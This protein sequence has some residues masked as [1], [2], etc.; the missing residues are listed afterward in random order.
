MVKCVIPISIQGGFFMKKLFVTV[1]LISIFSLFVFGAD[2]AVVA[3]NG[4]AATLY[5]ADMTDNYS[6]QV[7]RHIYEGLVEF[8]GEMNV[9]PALA[10]SWDIAADGMTYT[11]YLQED[12]KFQDGM[13]FHA[14]AVKLHF[15]KLLAGDLRR[16]SL[17]VP[18]VE[19]VKVVDD[20]TVKFNM[21][22][23]FG[24]FLN[25]L[26]HGAGLIVSPGILENFPKEEISN[27]PVGT[28][29]YEFVEWSKGDHIQLK[30]YD[31]YWQG[32]PKLDGINF[33][34]VPEANTRVLMLESGDSD[35]SD[36]IEPINVPRLEGKKGVDIVVTPSLT[37]RYVGFNMTKPPFDNKLVRQAAN[38]AIDKKGMAE[39]L[40][41]GYANPAKSVIAP[42][43]N[44]YY[45]T[46]GYPYNP[47]KAKELLAEAG[48]P[49]GFKTTLF[50]APH[51]K[52]IAVIVQSQLKAVGIDAKIDVLEWAS[53]MDLLY[54][55]SP[56]ESEHTMYVIGWS[57]STGDADWVV[58]PLF[59]SDN[60]PPNGDNHVGMA[61]DRVDELLK[62]E[63]TTFDPDERQEYLTELQKLLV[64]Q[65][66]WIF[67]YVQDE[68]VG[69]NTDLKDV[70]VLPL[71]VTVL[72]YAYFE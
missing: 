69:V 45:E 7:C 56:A 13:P 66:P 53:Y 58:R 63:M 31:R 67:L 21:K 11:F 65:A 38:Y 26:A 5:P 32:E 39:A 3:M 46:Q 57:P 30:A 18:F 2:E 10:E 50:A 36:M 15:D 33:K 41:R 35:V 12:V 43:V 14:D 25:H 29:P 64:E 49:D 34:I 1:L 23:P 16:S 19:S 9:V 70:M 28:G 68:L 8:D 42:K 51:Y 54:S 17:F 22:T 52:K 60:W 27:F 61:N 59:D 44:G 4:D 48:Y 71:G 20:Y 6:E 37:V 24:P 72:K 47:E 55:N 62:K 40:F